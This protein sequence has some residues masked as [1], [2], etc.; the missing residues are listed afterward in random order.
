MKGK[1]ILVLSYALVVV[2]LFM[3][4]GDMLYH[5][6]HALQATTCQNCRIKEDRS[7]W[8]CYEVDEGAVQCKV[9]GDSCSLFDVCSKNK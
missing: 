4:T 5:K 2:A 1:P 8:E 7:G 6:A 3:L 9:V